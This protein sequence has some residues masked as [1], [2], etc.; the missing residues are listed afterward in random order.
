MLP[1]QFFL[2]P[3][4]VGEEFTFNMEQGKTLFIKLMAIGPLNEA[5][6]KRDV[7]FLMNGEARVVAV[8]DDEANGKKNGPS[9]GGAGIAVRPKADPKEKGDIGAPMSG[10]VVE[11][12]VKEGAEV[13][14]G[15]PVVVM[16]AMSKSVLLKIHLRDWAIVTDCLPE[17]ETVV[18]AT[19]AGKVA[20]VL[21][22]QNDSLS[23]G[24]LVAKI[25]KQ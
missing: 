15:D 7:F 21:V 3:L 17:M 14:V 5:T 12:R 25:E 8:T 10:V 2:R 13:K 1:T 22:S 20:Q 18:T 4:K 23:A 11:V 9:G 24:D 6:G 16:S 19:Q